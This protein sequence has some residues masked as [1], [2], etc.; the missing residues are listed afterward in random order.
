[1]AFA[2]FAN[3]AQGQTAGTG[4]V[5]QGPDLELIQTEGLGFLTLAGDAKLRLTSQWS[6]PPAPT[7]SLLS[8]ASRKGLVA[9]AGPDSVIL[10][11]TE[12]V[13][14]AFEKPEENGSE[15]RSFDPQLRIPVPIRICQLTFT[16]DENYLILSAEQGG[17][18]AVYEVQSLLQ[19]ATQASF[20]I[21]TNGE[22]LRALLP[23]PSLEKADL[24][25]VVTN[26]GKLLMANMKA[27]DFAPG[28]NG[29]ILRE[30]V[31]CISWST[32]GKQLVAG[33]GD[34]T[35]V[36][37]TPEGNVK[38]EF[39]RPPSLDASY[40]G[41]PPAAEL[42]TPVTSANCYSRVPLLAGERSVDSYSRLDCATTAR[43]QMPSY[44]EAGE[45]YSVPV[46]VT[47]CRSV[48]K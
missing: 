43:E 14:K 35:I 16:A 2:G 15:I 18:L 13:R 32:K 46:A 27:R 41:E 22:S 31:S 3:A 47:S 30:Q 39:P 33:L 24:C 1:M 11:S 40:F 45:G 44:Y 28:S 17:G 29:Q 5:A 25:A 48:W 7:A 8:I 23:N 4:A 42:P 26:E 34:G 36:Q 19:G 12:S 37:M 9:A 6:P 38:A 21:P 20:E 10:A